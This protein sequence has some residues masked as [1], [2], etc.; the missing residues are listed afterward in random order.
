M[1]AP[2]KLMAIL[3]H[4]DD[5]SLGMGGTFAKYVSEGVE[6][7]LVTATKGERGR[8]GNLP[9]R[10][11]DEEVGKIREAELRCAVKKLGIHRLEFLDYLDADL[12]KVNPQ[13]AINKIAILIRDFR[14]DVVVTFGP[15]GG[16]GHPDHIA[17]SQFAGGA[18]VTATDATVQL[19]DAT[20]RILVPHAVKKFYYM[21]WTKTQWDGYQE[22]FKDLKMVVDNVERRAVP[23]PDWLI[24]TRLNT[25]KYTEQVW[26][27]VCCHESQLAVYEKLNELSP[28][29]H[30]GIWGVQEYYRVFSRVNGGRKIENDL[31]E[32]LR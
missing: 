22:A 4:P 9:E 26:S 13:E 12:D 3:A 20:N 8:C 32:G 1:S 18:I 28:E 19:Q 16:Y 23:A 5:E 21:T 31:F 11:S 10:P 2:L 15:D 24:T 17:I 29:N 7:C 6:C 25:E 14:P 30:R 27:A